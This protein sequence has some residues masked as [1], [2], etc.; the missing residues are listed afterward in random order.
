MNKLSEITAYL[1]ENKQYN[2]S[3]I[4][5]YCFRGI[6]ILSHIVSDNFLDIEE[7]EKDR[8]LKSGMFW[9][10][11]TLS[12]TGNVLCDNQVILLGV[13]KVEKN[14][15]SFCPLRIDYKQEN[16]DSCE[17]WVYDQSKE[18]TD[19]RLLIRYDIKDSGS[20]YTSFDNLKEITLSKIL[21][22]LGI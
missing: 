16:D 19:K 4:D 18:Y 17:I 3:E 8:F 2:K 12:Q 20:Y 22:E 15:S 5:K 10:I 14:K 11:P 21:K 9:E 1:K 13:Y 7:L 6:S